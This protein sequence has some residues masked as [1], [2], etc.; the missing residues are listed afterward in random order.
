[1][2]ID[3]RQKRMSA[4]EVGLPW[5]SSMI[6]PAE[7]GFL[8]NQRAAVAYLFSGEFAGPGGGDVSWMLRPRRRRNYPPK[9]LS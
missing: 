3:T 2:A 8:A 4:A 1:M 7:A 9:K 5:R 6:D